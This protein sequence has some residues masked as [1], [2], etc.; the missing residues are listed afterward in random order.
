MAFLVATMTLKYNKSS[1][2]GNIRVLYFNVKKL[3]ELNW[4]FPVKVYQNGIK[5]GFWPADLQF[6]VT[7][8]YELRRASPI[9]PSFAKLSEKHD[10]PTVLSL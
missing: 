6:V 8:Y 2:L 5:V 10:A 7:Q 4:K 3:R 9:R 1:K